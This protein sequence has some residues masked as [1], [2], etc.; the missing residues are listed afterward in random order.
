VG[1]GI[2]H[3]QFGGGLG[4]QQQVVQRPFV[5]AHRFAPAAPALHSR[6]LDLHPRPRFEQRPFERTTFPFQRR[7]LF[8][9]PVA[10]PFQRNIFV[11]PTLSSPLFVNPGLGVEA[12]CSAVSGGNIQI[13]QGCV[14]CVLSGQPDCIAQTVATRNILGLTN[15][16]I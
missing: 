10:V 11:N 3:R 2:S 13:E 12:Q 14:N 9:N 15:I 4:H 1:S 6:A 16:I 5:A 8:V 7:N